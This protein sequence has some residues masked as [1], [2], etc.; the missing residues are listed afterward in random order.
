MTTPSCSLLSLLA[1]L[2]A[3]WSDGTWS[4][5]VKPEVPEGYKGNPATLS[6]PLRQD[7]TTLKLERTGAHHA[8]RLEGGAAPLALTDV[9]LALFVPR[10]PAY[11]R[12]NDDLVR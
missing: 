9:D 4:V 10:V 2:S 6:P 3:P 8:L 12:G 7:L 5:P 11:A 1:L